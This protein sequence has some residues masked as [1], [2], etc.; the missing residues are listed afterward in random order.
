MNRKNSIPVTSIMSETAPTTVSSMNAEFS[1]I[2]SA[3]NYES[4]LCSIFQP[5]K[6][7]PEKKRYGRLMRIGQYSSSPALDDDSMKHINFDCD[8][9]CVTIIRYNHIIMPIF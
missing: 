4:C 5:V 6:D 2:K 7:M 3:V 8:T 9:K 1:K